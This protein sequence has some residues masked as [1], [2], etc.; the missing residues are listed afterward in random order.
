MLPCWLLYLPIALFLSLW[1][2]LIPGTTRF[3]PEACQNI[4]RLLSSEVV[5]Q[6]LATGA[7]TE[8]ICHHLAK[9]KG[10]V[11]SSYRSTP[12]VLSLHGPPGIGKSL[13]THLVSRALYNS[14]PDL[15]APCPGD[16]CQGAK[17]LTKLIR[18]WVSTKSSDKPRRPSRGQDN[19]QRSFVVL[20]S[21]TQ[22]QK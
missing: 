9:Q 8:A 5:G 22:I 2:T 3:V 14:D 6:S 19:K 17:S 15:S 11:S 21:V 1:I 12:L 7:M 4:E 16:G 10:V 13:S 18:L 20:L